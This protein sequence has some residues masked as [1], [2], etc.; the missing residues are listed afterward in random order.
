MRN[1]TPIDLDDPIELHGK[2]ITTIE[3]KEPNGALHSKLGE[4]RIFVRNSDTTGSFVE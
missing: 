4:P 1:T 2:K 3:L